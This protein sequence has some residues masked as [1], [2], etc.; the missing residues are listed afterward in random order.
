M[1]PLYFPV[2]SIT[3]QLL[4]LLLE[5][6]VRVSILSGTIPVAHARDRSFD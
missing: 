5:S 2:F 4:P 6:H 3:R 1:Y